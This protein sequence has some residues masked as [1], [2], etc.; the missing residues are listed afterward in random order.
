MEYSSKEARRAPPLNHA[1]SL[2]SRRP[3]CWTIATLLDIASP[4]VIQAIRL[5]RTL[6]PR[7][8]MTPATCRIRASSSAT[9]S[10]RLIGGASVHRVAVAPFG[11]SPPGASR[12]P[13]ALQATPSGTAHHPDG[14][15]SQCGPH[16]PTPR[17]RRIN[18]KPPMA[19]PTQST[20]HGEFPILKP[21]SR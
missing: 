17:L 12:C 7:P 14:A 15:R 6:P 11:V 4:V 16:E 21:R 19:Q 20:R 1:G 3:K 8:L 5:R 13:A 10:S 2:R 18:S 9:T